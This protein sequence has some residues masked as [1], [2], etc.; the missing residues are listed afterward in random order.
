[1]HAWHSFLKSSCTDSLH[2]STTRIQR[3]T[4]FKT[5]FFQTCTHHFSQAH[6]RG[7]ACA[8]RHALV[9]SS[10]GHDKLKQNLLSLIPRTTRSRQHNPGPWWR[11]C[12]RWTACTATS[13]PPPRARSQRC[14]MFALCN[15]HCTKLQASCDA[16]WPQPLLQIVQLCLHH[17]QTRIHAHIND[18]A[19]CCLIATSTP[20]SW[21]RINTF[22]QYTYTITHN[23]CNTHICNTQHIQLHT[24]AQCKMLF[25]GHVDANKLVENLEVRGQ[26]A[27]DTHYAASCTCTYSAS[28][29]ILCIGVTVLHFAL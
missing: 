9:K 29:A 20:T 1:M 22:K 28:A 5:Y 16:F 7:A 13:C 23:I 25:D 8:G 4:A 18:S 27:G 10:S 6:G 21:W 3:P 26:A 14:A 15:L 2:T 11:C 24:I 12:V 17:R 19:R